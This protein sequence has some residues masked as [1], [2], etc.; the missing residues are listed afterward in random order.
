MMGLMLHAKG[1]K[2]IKQG[3]YKDAL[4]VLSMGEVSV[5]LV[6]VLLRMCYS[7]EQITL[8]LVH[9]LSFL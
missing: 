3:N 2:L 1:K 8:K 4:E 5:L 7:D 6:Y 9:S